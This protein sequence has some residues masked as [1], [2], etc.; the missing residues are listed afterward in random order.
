MIALY[1]DLCSGILYA[2]GIIVE[3]DR[4]NIDDEK[5]FNGFG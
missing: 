4:A 2:L 1:R 5:K 3:I